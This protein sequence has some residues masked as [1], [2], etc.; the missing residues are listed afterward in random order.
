MTHSVRSCP[1]HKAQGVQESEPLAVP[2]TRAQPCSGQ[3]WGRR[4][5]ATARPTPQCTPS[6]RR[7][8]ATATSEGPPPATKQQRCPR[9]RRERD[10]ASKRKWVRKRRAAV[11]SS[12][13]TSRVDLMTFC[14]CC[15]FSSF[16]RLLTCFDVHAG[17]GRVGGPGGWW[18]RL[19]MRRSNRHHGRSHRVHPINAC[20]LPL[21]VWFHLNSSKRT[22][23]PG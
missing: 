21:G 9:R 14:C 5:H 20:G 13:T 7:Q 8:R 10:H 15:C 11:V 22:P 23:V 3:W 17:E 12:D 4:S 1:P 18:V 16:A 19:R 6:T 2:L